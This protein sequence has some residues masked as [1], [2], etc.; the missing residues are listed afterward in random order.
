MALVR[1]GRTTFQ[2]P[3]IF[4]GAV[5]GQ[6]GNFIKGGLRNR[7]VGGLNP[8]FSGYANGH[9]SPSSFILPQKSG[10]IS[11]YT[12]SSGEIVGSVTLTPARNLEGSA[13]LTISVTNAQL[14][15]IVSLAATGSLS[16]QKLD[17]ILAGAAALAGSGTLQITVADAQAGAIFS[18]TATTTGSIASDSTLTALAF[19]IA[20]AGGPTPL[21]P[22][23][24]A[25]AVWDTV[26]A[27]HVDTG[28]TGKALSDAGGAGNPWS[29]DL[30]T[31]NDPGT[32]GNLVQKLLTVAK[33]LGLK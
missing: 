8:T 25:N 33:F 28:T 7:N 21:S 16:I 11:S 9:L 1:N 23:G 27:E 17:A 32:F 3:G 20:E 22:E 19:M 10:S 13:S 14:D 18:V 24:L 15:Q 4:S 30:S 6:S 2:N 31:N 5:Y 29:A 26:L 12:E